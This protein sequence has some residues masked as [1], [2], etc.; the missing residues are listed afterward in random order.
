FSRV[1][2][3]SLCCNS[4]SIKPRQQVPAIKSKSVSGKI[5]F[6]QR[7]A[8]HI[9]N[10]KSVIGFYGVSFDFES[11]CFREWIWKSIY[12]NSRYFYLAHR[13]FYFNKI[14]QLRAPDNVSGNIG[15]RTGLITYI[16]SSAVENDCTCG[17]T[18]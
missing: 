16:D 15:D 7:P 9:E 12:R 11:C 6:S 3:N 18:Q 8:G 14:C 2:Q 13:S 17:V 5:F 1:E 4:I 10:F